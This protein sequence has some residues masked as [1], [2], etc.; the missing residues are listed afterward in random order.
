MDQTAAEC[1]ADI[2]RRYRHP[3]SWKD[4]R[5]TGKPHLIGKTVLKVE[6]IRLGGGA[7]V[8]AE[9]ARANA[10][11]IR[12]FAQSAGLA[13]YQL[14]LDQTVDKAPYVVVPTQ[15]FE[16]DVLPVLRAL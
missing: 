1:G 16:I 12:A 5:S 14:T 4:G 6:E 7:F 11:A 13:P 10:A 9:D 2:F 15:Y 3:E 8:R